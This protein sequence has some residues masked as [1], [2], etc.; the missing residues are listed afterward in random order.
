MKRIYWRPHKVS[1]LGLSA[2]AAASLLG[3]ALV[4]CWPVQRRD[5]QRAL[6]WEAVRRAAAMM[7]ELKQER[8]RR[9]LPIEPGFD[10][11]RTGLV[12]QAMSLVTSRPSDLR[13]KQTSINPNFAAAIVDM[14]TEAGVRPGDTVAVGWSGSFPAL[15]VSLCAALDTLG[16]QSLILASA[17]SSQYGANLPEFM[18]LDMERH[19]QEQSLTRCRSAA[20]TF[21]AGADRGLGLSDEALAHIEQVAARN[22]V[23]LLRSSRRLLAVEQRLDWYRRAASGT[24]IKAFLNVGGGVASTGGEKGQHLFQ[25]GLNRHVGA[26]AAQV[27]CVMARFAASGTPVIHLNHVQELAAQWGFPVAPETFPELGV[28]RPFQDQQPNRWL[29]LVVLVGILASMRCCVWSGK[30]QLALRRLPRWLQAH[31]PVAIHAPNEL[32]TEPQLMV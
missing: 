16:V 25:A 12:G 19:L 17:T 2:V 11:A 26:A 9:G 32:D 28:G 23:P 6:K 4:V 14:L 29:A 10:P 21:G 31:A 5:G 15:N 8:L 22:D 13:S 20:V 24:P 3:L 7:H 30:G 27:D 18:W 1:K